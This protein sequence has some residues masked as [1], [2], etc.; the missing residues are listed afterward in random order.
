MAT[1]LLEIGTEELPARF[2]AGNERELLSRFEEGLQAAGLGHG[3]ISVRSTPRR[4]V[5]R[6]EDLESVQ[7]LHEELIM[8]PPARVAFDANGQPSKAAEGFARTNHVSVGALETVSTEKGD[9]LAVRVEKGGASAADV[10]ASLAPSVIAALPFAKKMRWGSGDFAFARPLRWIVSLLDDVVVPFSVGGVDAGRETFGH[11]EHGYGPFVLENAASYDAVMEQGGVIPSADDR[12]AIIVSGGTAQAEARGGTVIWK[13]SLLD[14][15]QGLC[16]HPEPLL[17]D[18]DPRYLEVP[19]EVLLTSMETHQ[20]SFGVQDAEG[21]LL[22]HFLTVLN[23]TPPDRELVKKGW[24]RVL[25]ARLEDA[26]FF[27]QTDLKSSFDAWLKELDSVIFLAPL[28]SMGDKTRR[29]SA[30]CEWL[31]KNT[32][33]ADAPDHAPFVLPAD[34]ARAGRLSKADL[35]SSM[36]G[37]FDTLQGIMGGI[38]ARRMG[39]KENIAAALAEQYLPA[40]PETPVPATDMG[41]VL[42]VADKVDTLVGCFGLGMIPTGTADPYALRRAALGIA[43]I[44]LERGLLLD[45]AELFDV[46]RALYGERKWKLDESSAKARLMEFFVARVKNLFLTQGHDTLFV[47]AVT[48]SG[49]EQ[50]WRTGRR[51]AALESFGST[52][53]FLPAAQTFKRVSNIIRKH[54]GTETLTG[55][56]AADLLQEEAEKA[57]AA[58]VGTAF[59]DYDECYAA[60]EF[61]EILGRMAKLRPYVDAFFGDVMVMCDDQ[62]LRKNR[63]N[64]LKTIAMRLERVADFAALQM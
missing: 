45:V 34:A 18:I 10:L 36:V 20:K 39:E 62:T 30:L 58:Q 26:R 22:P 43:R 1:F 32:R 46:A 3:L 53:D 8:G 31:A 42:S 49:A 40:G 14:E 5:V 24:E 48:A 17:G 61:G 37:E 54:G 19:R 6:V 55:E 15:V 27:W 63:L 38:Y 29:V 28:G 2:L 47:E 4:A 9:Y 11:R 35:V 7:P 16:E 56:Y 13:D 44:M 59:V 52:E 41:A 50:V 51:L 25:R 23:M 60:A 64:L 57:L 33:R 12:R 21:K